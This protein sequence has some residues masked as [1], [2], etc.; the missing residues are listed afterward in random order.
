[1]CLRTKVGGDW[2]MITIAVGFLLRDVVG[3]CEVDGSARPLVGVG[4]RL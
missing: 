2:W 1:M 4:Q 3:D